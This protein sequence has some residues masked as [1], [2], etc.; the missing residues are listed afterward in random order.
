MPCSSGAGT[1]PSLLPVVQDGHME[2]HVFPKQGEKMAAGDN[3][4]ALQWFKSHKQPHRAVVV[5][6]LRNRSVKPYAVT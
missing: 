1:G 2:L 4:G 3:V 6:L 5:E